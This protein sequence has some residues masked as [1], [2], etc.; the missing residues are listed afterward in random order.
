MVREKEAAD[1]SGMDLFEKVN[2][3][4]IF[5]DVSCVSAI[6]CQGQDQLDPL[7]QKMLE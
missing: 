2:K 4:G 7:I 6:Q 3:F 5:Q 1:K